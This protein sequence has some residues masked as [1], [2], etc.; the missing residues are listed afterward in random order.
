MPKN[1]KALSYVGKWPT[2]FQHLTP[3]ELEQ[4]EQTTLE[5]H[6]G[7]GEI[8]RKQ[9]SP[10]THIV[11]INE[12]LTKLYLEGEKNIVL[13][14]LKSG[15]IAGGPGIY[16]DFRHHYTIK[17][18][19]DVSVFF[20]K[21]DIIKDLLYKNVQFNNEF[22]R[23]ISINTLISYERLINLTQKHI[24]GRMASTIIYLSE[25]IYKSLSFKNL[26]SKDDM[27]E[28]VSTTRD[29]SMKILKDFHQ[30]GIISME[31]DI[32]EIKNFNL[33]QEISNKGKY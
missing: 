7:K 8:V 20:F 28:L 13:R 14:L 4:I 12:G 30:L 5:V 29:N 9:G 17:A 24:P 18:I 10:L 26:L 21:V 22:N 11:T 25:E 16:Y 6:F 2:M 31:E 27:A 1:K 15:D 23:E 3:S 32:I 33:L 19:T